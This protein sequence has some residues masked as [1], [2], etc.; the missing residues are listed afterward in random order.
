MNLQPLR[1]LIAFYKDLPNIV[2][3]MADEAVM[4][5]SDWIIE[6]NINQL[7]RG[8][9]ANGKPLKYARPRSTP[10]NAS[11][12]YTNP[13]SKYK[14]KKGGQT[15]VVDLKQT[16]EFYG[17]LILDRERAGVYKIISLSNADLLDVLNKM[18]TPDITGLNQSN[19]SVLVSK[20]GEEINRRINV[21]INSF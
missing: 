6:Q 7:S 21:K 3:R 19:T 18:Y 9:D 20:L 11:G 4:S 14:S 13:Y 17:S 10:L 12:A 5:L 16:G 1:N 2:F 8:T 15:A